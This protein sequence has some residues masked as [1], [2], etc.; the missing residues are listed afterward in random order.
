MLIYIG[1][2]VGIATIIIVL[3]VVFLVFLSL[4]FI[5]WRSIKK[6]FRKLKN[7]FSK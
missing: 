3:I 6:I 2:G 7:L 5:M 4:G 1:P